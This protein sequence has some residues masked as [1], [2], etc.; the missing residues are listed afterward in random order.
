MSSRIIFV[1]ILFFG[2]AV[3]SIQ[4]QDVRPQQPVSPIAAQQT[5]QERQVPNA[6]YH[7]GQGDV[8]ELNFPFTPEFNQTVTVQPDGFVTLQV[9]GDVKVAGLTT[10]EVKTRLENQYSVALKNPVITVILKEFEKPSFT[11]SGEVGRPGKYEMKDGLTLSQAVAFAGGF[12][13]DAKH[14]QVLLFRRS[15][16]EWVEVKELDMKKFLK[17][18]DKQDYQVKPGDMIYVPRRK[19]AGLKPLMPIG[20][21]VRMSIYP[22]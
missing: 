4:A 22:F 5:Y 18:T 11:A 9:L 21:F 7:I 2:T 17:G 14:T 12:T 10:S 13:G 20:A 19:L 8:I 6:R 16:N 1:L 15:S 3:A